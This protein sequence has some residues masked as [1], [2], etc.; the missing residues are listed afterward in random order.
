MSLT[1][2][3]RWIVIL[4]PVVIGIGYIIY[5]LL[6]GGKTSIPASYPKAGQPT[7]TKPSVPATVS[8]S[9]FPLKVGSGNKL[10]PNKS[11]MALQDALGVSIDGIFGAKTL[12]A[13]QQQANLSTIVDANQLSTVI[14]QIEQNDAASNK[15]SSTTEQ[16]LNGYDNNQNLSYLNVTK[17]SNWLQITQQ[18]DGSFIYGNTQFFVG[19]GTQFDI[20]QVTP[21]V[22][23]FGTGKLVILDTRST[24]NT[25]WLA[26]PNNIYLS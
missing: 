17:D 15:T 5:T 19:N 24:P 1:K 13:L 4:T 14:D 25:Y 26:D 18:A 7:G 22:E 3:Q 12:A 6:K 11:V 10:N 21:D 16:L 8:T 20:T 2:T 23:D 9:E